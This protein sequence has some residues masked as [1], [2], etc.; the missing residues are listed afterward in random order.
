MDDDLN[1]LAD[2]E[3]NRFRDSYVQEINEREDGLAAD[4]ASGGMIGSGFYWSIIKL[5]VEEAKTL[6]QERIRIEKDLML[7]KYGSLDAER[8]EELKSTVKE[9]IA[10]VFVEL[11]NNQRL[12]YLPAQLKL[13]NSKLIHDQEISLMAEG[14]RDIEIEKGREK[15]RIEGE[16]RIR[17]SMEYVTSLIEIFKLRDNLNLIFKKKFGFEIF[18]LHQE[19]VLAEIVTP[20]RDETDFVSKMLVLGNLIDWMDVSSLRSALNANFKG[21]QSITLLEELLKLNFGDFD[22]AII[23]NLRLI[24][25]LRNTKFP[26]HKEGEEIIGIFKKLGSD[27]P[28]KDWDFVW[29]GVMKLY[30]DSITGLIRLLSQ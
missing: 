26:I 13:E 12:Q 10:K 23:K 24:M 22:S 5:H 20:C 25:K 2:L 16:R 11:Y 30:E 21:A 19:G 1:K 14:D 7:K 17:Y 27:Y 4:C 15:V 3:Y 28:P 8:I 18:K 6:Y 29:K 9:I